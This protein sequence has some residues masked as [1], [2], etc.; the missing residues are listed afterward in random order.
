MSATSTTGSAMGDALLSAQALKEEMGKSD[1]MSKLFAALDSM[2]ANF[3]HWD[4]RILNG[5]YDITSYSIPSSM[6]HSSRND[7]PQSDEEMPQEKPKISNVVNEGCF[8]L[9]IQRL[10]YF[11]R[12]GKR[13]KPVEQNHSTLKDINLRFESGKMYLVLGAPGCGKVSE[14]GQLRLKQKNKGLCL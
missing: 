7:A 1:V 13:P 12:T 8:Y 5:S 2:G 3:S 6:S 10:S 11:F 4:L 9:L 14:F